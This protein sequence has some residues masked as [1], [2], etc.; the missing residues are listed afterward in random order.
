M[1]SLFKIFRVEQRVDAWKLC[2]QCRRPEPRACEDIG[3]WF[4]IFEIISYASVLVNSGLVA[5]TSAICKNYTWPARVWIFFGMSAGIFFVK[6]VVAEYVP[7]TPRDVEIQVERNK[8]FID[9][10]VHNV[11]DDDDDA[12]MSKDKVVNKYVI[13]INDDDPL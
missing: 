8:Y 12:L 5:F 1:F 9:K 7:D 2:Q 3:T 11:P 10:I 6:Y 4:P 13:R